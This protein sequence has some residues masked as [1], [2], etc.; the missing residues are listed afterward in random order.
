MSDNQISNFLTISLAILVGVFFILLIVLVVL[1][2]K[3]KSNNKA[4][5]AE[6]NNLSD[7]AKKVKKDIEYTKNSIFGDY[8]I[9]K[10][11]NRGYPISIRFLYISSVFSAMADLLCGVS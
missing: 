7:E 9:E 2:L 6:S 11:R 5:N 1:I 4:K 10:N 3:D 8:G